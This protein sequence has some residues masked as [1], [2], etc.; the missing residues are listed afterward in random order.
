M[1][2][3]GICKKGHNDRDD[4]F[5]LRCFIISTHVNGKDRGSVRLFALS[6]CQWCHKTKALLEELGVAFDYD[7]VDLLTGEEQNAVLDVMEKWSPNGAFP[8][9][10]IDDKRAIQGFR[11]QEIREALEG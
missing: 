5:I 1:V 9:I 4:P 7:Y 11:E 2:R 8:T 10:V 3:P 6:T